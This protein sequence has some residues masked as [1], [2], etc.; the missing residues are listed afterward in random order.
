TTGADVVVLVPP[1]SHLRPV[2]KSIAGALGSDT[3]LVVATKGV[4]EGSHK[5][6]SEVLAETLPAVPVERITF[7]S[8]PS[9]AKEVARGLPT[10]V[11][12]AS[13][14]MATARRVQPLF[15]APMFRVY[16]S[17]D[18]I[19]VQVGGAIKNVMAVATG[20]CDGLDLGNNARAALI[21]RGLA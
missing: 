16:T 1:S 5:L 4:E 15:H 7:L 13:R 17:D 20:V 9:F 19:G 11:A 3:I 10:D 6:M 18:P 2:S 8:G 14:S 21:T 12:V